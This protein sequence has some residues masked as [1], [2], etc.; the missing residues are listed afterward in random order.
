VAKRSEIER[1]ESEVC[2]NVT[3][4][5]VTLRPE[6]EDL[7]DVDDVEEADCWWPRKDQLQSLNA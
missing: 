2:V 5:G 1:S 3:N 7:D 6:V 4:G